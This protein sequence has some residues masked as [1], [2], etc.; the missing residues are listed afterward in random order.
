MNTYALIDNDTIVNNVVAAS[1]ELAE[2]LTGYKAIEVSHPQGPY[3]GWTFDQENGLWK[4][5]IVPEETDEYSVEWNVESGSWVFVLRDGV[6]L[7]P[8]NN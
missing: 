2:S 8:P 1:K 7:V 3:V 5:P 6:E 4:N